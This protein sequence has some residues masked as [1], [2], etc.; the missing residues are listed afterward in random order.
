MANPK[1]IP[2]LVDC[3]SS[4]DAVLIGTGLLSDERSSSSEMGEQLEPRLGHVASEEQQHG[5][6]QST[7]DHPILAGPSAAPLLAVLGLRP[8]HRN[9]VHTCHGFPGRYWKRVFRCELNSANKP[10]LFVQQALAQGILPNYM[11]LKVL[12]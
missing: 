9:P 7:V 12:S 6:S 4:E 10:D 5:S 2:S 8:V 11:F 3:S 1:S